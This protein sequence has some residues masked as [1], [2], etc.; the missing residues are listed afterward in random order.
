M[1]RI[2][3]DL[4]HDVI[5]IMDLTD[6]LVQ[7]VRIF[8]MIVREFIKRRIS[9]NPGGKEIELIV[10]ILHPL[11][12]RRFTQNQTVTAFRAKT[13][14]AVAPFRIRHFDVMRF[15]QH[16]KRI[17]VDFLHCKDH[18][19]PAG[20]AFNAEK[21]SVFFQFRRMKMNGFPGTFQNRERCKPDQIGKSAG[22]FP[23]QPQGDLHT[24]LPLVHENSGDT[25][26]PQFFH[27][28]L[29]KFGITHQEGFH[30]R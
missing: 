16:N 28:T 5:Q 8:Q 1:D 29:N 18:V 27:G 4:R 21:K 7:S 17:F 12:N 11:R 23:D 25:G 3:L 26:L 20:D 14:Q 24:H 15:I 13:D 6:P 30:E 22:T 10:Q 2:G 9:E 19:L